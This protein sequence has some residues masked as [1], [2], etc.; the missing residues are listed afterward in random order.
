M[1]TEIQQS[2]PWGTTIKLVVGLTL[3]AIAAGLLLHFQ[4]VVTSLLIA[5]VL[6]YLF[7]PL[8]K[9]LSSTTRLSWQLSTGIVF[10]LMIA[11]LLGALTATGVAIVQQF[12]SLLQI[13]Q[14]FIADLPDIAT[15][16]TQHLGQYGYLAELID[17]NNLANQLIEALQPVLGQAGSLV[18]SFATGA[19]TGIG[20][21]FFVLMIAYFLLSDADKF[22]NR[23]DLSEIP[24]YNYDIQ[25][26]GRELRK[27]WNAFLRGQVILFVL[28]VIIYTLTLSL[29]GVRYAIG[30]ALLTGLSRFI[31]Y[32]GIIATLVVTGL[33]TFFQPSNYL[34]LNPWQYTALILLVAFIIDKIFDSFVA[35]RFLGKALGIHPATVLIAAII[36][37]SLLGLIGLILAAPVVATLKL[38]G[39]YIFRKMF[40][41]Y[42]WPEEE[43]ESVQI[44]YPWHRLGRSLWAWVQSSW[45]KIRSPRK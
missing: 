18:S 6:T 2:P 39:G 17:L 21:L 43:T 32:V 22:S 12:Q 20:K 38:I 19:A 9:F 4:S 16:I 11:L 24:D 34:G 10:I 26:M 1:T 45:R 42:P 29:L 37:A 5:C 3:V 13:L 35:P 14:T 28:T 27:V 23:L 36:A 40:D 30:L 15:N 7:H 25:R 33:A 41:L 44:E 8:V 31:P